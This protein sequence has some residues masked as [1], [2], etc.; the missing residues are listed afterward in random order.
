MHQPL[1]A[2]PF[3]PEREELPNAPD[4]Q[5]GKE[6]AS[7][8]RTRTAGLR[9]RV[10]LAL[11]VALGTDTALSQQAKQPKRAPPHRRVATAADTAYPVEDGMEERLLA[12]DTVQ[13]FQRFL[14]AHAEYREVDG[15]LDFLRRY[16]QDPAD[17]LEEN[18][19]WKGACNNFAELSATWA[20]M[21][22][23]IPYVVTLCPGGW[24]AKLKQDWHQITVCRLPGNR[25]CIFN[26]RSVTPF[27]GTLQE[28]LRQ[29]YPDMKIWGIGG[30]MEWR[31]VQNTIRAKLYQHVLAS[32]ADPD[33]LR[34][35][36]LPFGEER[37]PEIA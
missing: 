35:A 13:K 36:D 12:L 28:Y 33:G 2:L 3:F 29:E 23:G 25:L 32:N 4:G 10:L 34:E 8:A 27:E 19:D 14:D 11:A 1:T 30:V 21:H 17:C 37:A 9:S 6:P 16:R 22:G 31:R 5:E 15:M 26:E 7:P 18:G 20:A 24:V